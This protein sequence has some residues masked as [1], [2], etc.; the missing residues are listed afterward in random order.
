MLGKPEIVA[1]LNGHAAF[2]W[3]GSSLKAWSE[4]LS[5]SLEL[6]IDPILHKALKQLSL[7]QMMRGG[8]PIIGNKEFPNQGKLYVNGKT[9]SGV[10]R[11]SESAIVTESV[12]VDIS[13]KVDLQRLAMNIKLTPRSADLLDFTVPVMVKGSL[14]KPSITPDSAFIQNNATAIGTVVGGPAGAAV[15]AVIEKAFAGNREDNLKAVRDNL[16]NILG[17]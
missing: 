16:M 13:G 17:N 5:G 12:Q 14:F 8:L 11:L 4:E 1:P 6:S 3:R 2:N 9:K 15:G 10:L 7:V